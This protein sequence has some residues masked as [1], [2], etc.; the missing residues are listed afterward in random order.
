MEEAIEAK[1]RISK[2][3]ES[4][5]SKYIDTINRFLALDTAL[6]AGMASVVSFLRPGSGNDAVGPLADKGFLAWGLILLILSLL[7]AI[8]VRLLAQFFMELEVLLPVGEV[9][10]YFRDTPHYTTSYRTEPSIVERRVR[11]MLFL[12]ILSA[13]NFILGLSLLMFFLYRNLQ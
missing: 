10:E 8:G 4:L 11:V 12:I 1:N 2:K 3:L 7:T 13:I 9:E 5:W 6:I